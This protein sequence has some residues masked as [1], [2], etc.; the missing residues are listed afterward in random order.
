MPEDVPVPGRSFPSRWLEQRLAALSDA[1]L[2]LLV[3]LVL[4]ALSAWPLLL[5][6]L[7]PFQDL[8]NH[9]ATAHIIAHPD[10]YPQFAFNGLF[11]SNAL[12]TLWLYVVGSHG[13]FGAARAFIAIVL[14]A[15]ALALPLFVLHFVG[16]ARSAGR[17]A[18]RLAPGPQL[19]RR[20]GV[21][22]LRVRVRAVAD[23]ADRA[24][25]TARAPHRGARPR[26]RRA[27]G[28]D[29]VRAPVPARGR[30][31]AGR[32]AR[33]HAAPPGGHASRPA[34]RCCCRS[35]PA[36][37]LSLA[38]AQQHL[39]K[40]EHATTM[41]AGTF[42]YLNP[43]EI[44]AHLWTDVSGALTRWGSMTIVPALL[45]AV[46]RLEA[47]AR[48]GAPVPSRCRRWRCSPPPTSACP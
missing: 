24:R 14:A 44:V 7:P 22:E 3:A 29:L 31:R 35:R 18:V 4:F 15:N 45:L 13:L 12:L 17:D 11:K 25:S 26:H 27:L 40:A 8:P 43:W 46:V 38:A 42:S 6:E 41:A 20:D 47:A 28:R 32:A 2:T 34:S 16:T 37:L 36:A 39:V 10:L 30:G 9:V 21:L 23:P 5:V 33:R 19:L 48:V 1:R